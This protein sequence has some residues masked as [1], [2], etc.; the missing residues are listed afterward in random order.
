MTYS[1]PVFLDSNKSWATNYTSPSF[2]IAKTVGFGVE[3]IL[4]GTGT[5][6]MAFQVS[7]DGTN[8]SL[9]PETQLS[10]TGAGNAG[11]EVDASHFLFANAIFTQLTGTL[12]MV[13]LK[14]NAKGS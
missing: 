3:A 12:T 8:F 13:S 10:I 1:I 7:M 14:A 2:E 11:I 4:T 6:T 5:G 9:L